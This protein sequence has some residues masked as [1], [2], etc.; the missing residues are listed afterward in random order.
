M[1]SASVRNR[2][3]LASTSCSVSAP[4]AAVSAAATKASMDWVFNTVI[5]P[6]G[7]MRF[8]VEDREPRGPAARR[9]NLPDDGLTL[10][11]LTG[12][13]ATPRGFVA[14]RASDSTRLGS[15]ND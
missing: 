14:H 15:G 13:G 10:R 2:S 1:L 11:R 3:S 8:E 9:H 7:A 12:G 6:R 4:S 5:A